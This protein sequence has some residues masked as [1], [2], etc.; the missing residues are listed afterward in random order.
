MQKQLTDLSF[1]EPGLK[2]VLV[3]FAAVKAGQT[4]RVC[5]CLA[6]QLPAAQ[7]AEL[8]PKAL[9]GSAPLPW[10]AQTPVRSYQLLGT[11]TLPCG[12]F[13]PKKG[14]SRRA[15]LLQRHEERQAVASLRCFPLCKTPAGNSAHQQC[16]WGWRLQLHQVTAGAR[17]ENWRNVEDSQP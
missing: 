17:V 10:L 11:P 2:G 15:Q 14:S 16:C 7:R 8:L 5:V 4:G 9:W 6:T 3:P 13:Y 1:P 12:S